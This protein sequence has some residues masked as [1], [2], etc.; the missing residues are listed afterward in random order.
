MDIP[1]EEA[2]NTNVNITTSQ[3]SDVL[4][5]IPFQVPKANIPSGPQTVFTPI[6][7]EVFPKRTLLVLSKGMSNRLSFS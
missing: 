1:D 4:S 6:V 2:P 5:D 7:E 3:Q